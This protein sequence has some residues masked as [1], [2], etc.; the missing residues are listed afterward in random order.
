MQTPKGGHLDYSS[1]LPEGITDSLFKGTIRAVFSM[2]Q[3]IQI[4][5]DCEKLIINSGRSY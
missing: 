2:L 3:I 5:R 4:E 1:T